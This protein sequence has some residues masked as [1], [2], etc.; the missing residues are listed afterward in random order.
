MPKTPTTRLHIGI[1]GWRY[2]PWRGVFY[3]EGLAQRRE[4][5]F[6]SRHVNTIEINGTFYSLQRPEYFAAWRDDTPNR[7]EFSVKGPR[8]ITHMKKLKEVDVAVANFFAS[9]MLALKEKLGPILWQFPPNMKYDREKFESFLELLPRD[10]KSAAA[11]AK[12]HEPRLKGRALTETDKNR[13]L[14]H[15]F[16]IRHE[17]F[18]VPEF[19]ELLR[20]HNAALVIADT[21]RHFPMPEDVTADFMYIRLHGDEEL[22][23]SGYSDVALDRW[24]A[25][26]KLWKSGKQPAD[27]NRI[28]IKAP[29]I[30]N[31][32]DIH[33][34]FDN[35]VKVHAPRDAMKLAERLGIE[36][37]KQ[38]A[39]DS[40]S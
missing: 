8:F 1:S 9:G 16:E 10:T 13:P 4:L 3:P 26:I 19:V 25:R 33:V 31:S 35:D 12:K 11:L 38:H 30:E 37:R 21:A 34:H 20:A 23:A 32:R 40:E 27:A 14:H 29:P 24:A 39:G 28:S 7:F 5:E 36:W 15:A 17:S 6:A 18:L 22:Y 2:D